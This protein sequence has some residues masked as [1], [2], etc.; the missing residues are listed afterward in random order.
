MN[1]KCDLLSQLISKYWYWSEINTKTETNRISME[2]NHKTYWIIANFKQTLQSKFVSGFILTHS[3][4]FSAYS[5]ESIPIPVQI[6]HTYKQKLSAD[7]FYRYLSDAQFCDP[8]V[9]F[10]YLLFSFE[11]DALSSN[12]YS[13]HSNNF[14]WKQRVSSIG[15]TAGQVGRA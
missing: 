4:F 2:E 1:K 14:V 6:Q 7:C 3:F 11:R 9:R 12:V 10:F 8:V 13:I 15:S 5:I